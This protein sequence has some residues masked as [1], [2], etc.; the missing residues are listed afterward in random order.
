LEPTYIIGIDLGGTNVRA[1]VVNSDGKI[2]GE[3]REP[4]LAMSGLDTT[5]AQI[6]KA[7]RSAVAGAGI[8]FSQ[9]IGAGMGVPGQHKSR[10]GIVLWSPNFKD[11]NGVQLLAP[12]REAIGVPIYM[13][14]DVNVAALGEYKFGA[15]RS[16]KSMIML[17]LGTGIGGGIILDGKLWLGTGEL[18]AEIGHQVIMP[19]GPM[20][21]C[22]R[23]GHLEA[24]ANRDAI[25]E[26]AARKI[27]MGRPSVLIEDSDWPDW[28]VTP[29]AIAKAAQDGDQVAIE[30]MAET[31]YYVGLGVANVINMLAP[32]MVIIGGGIAQAGDVLWGPILRTVHAHALTESRRVCR[33]VPADLGDDA[34]VMGGVGLCMQEI[35]NEK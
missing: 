19:D 9:V 35:E 13:G 18:A 16:T 32:E 2:V 6:I 26:R 28:S 34:G 23:A 27:Q 12:I 22:G 21:G 7:I 31:G 24:L 5:V 29:A 17:T 11:W 1:A 14:N 15:G 30:T 10:E 25:I 4:S 33:V 3:G 8:D 20:C